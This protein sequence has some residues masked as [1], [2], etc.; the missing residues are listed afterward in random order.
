[1]KY[2]SVGIALPLAIIFQLSYDTGEIPTQWKYAYI[3]PV[4]KKGSRSD[5]I[6]YRPIS[7]TSPVS[8]LMERIVVDKVKFLFMNR[9][10]SRQF[11]F[12]PKKSC[13]LALLDSIYHWQSSLKN[14]KNVDVIY[15]D[16]KSAFDM[17]KHDKLLYKLEKFGF[18]GKLCTW[19]KSF[20]SER[21]SFVRVDSA[22]SQKCF[23][24]PS[25]VLQGTVSG[26]IL[27]LIYINDIIQTIHNYPD[28]QFTLF[29][30]DLKLFGS[31]P[32]SLQAC[33]NDIVNWSNS[34]EIPLAE[35]KINVL[36]LGSNNP[37]V[38]YLLR[39]IPINVVSKVK[40]LGVIIDDKL[41]F[42]AHI[43]AQCI[44]ANA[45]ANKILASFNFNSPFLYMS[46]FK[47]Y[48]QPLLEYCTE[49]FSPRLNSRLLLSLER[50]LRSF[51]KIVFQR[52]GI[53]FD[54]YFDRLNVVG[55]SPL[56]Y[57]RIICDIVQVYKILFGLSHLPI[58]PFQFCRSPRYPLR[59]YSC[60]PM[61]NDN[62]CFFTRSINYWNKVCKEISDL[63]NVDQ[64]R[65]FLK[66][67]DVSIFAP[68][69]NGLS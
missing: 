56:F 5:P 16:F 3:S 24:V 1:M 68:I 25:G 51:S 45:V 57:R 10:I 54:S 21:K 4:F 52:C 13:N 20:L 40:D 33:V 31:N 6:N 66:C 63:K 29:A 19:I 8:R 60:A 67:L 35:N 41:T 49:I 32:I 14:K 22:I 17:I 34:W 64:V 30:D 61:F 26:P 65:E 11:G 59:M 36:H 44:K 38:S 28:V 53:P 2:L 9:F 62:N 37:H 18:D 47:T 7:L 58:H 50:P 43:N 69:P 55:A 48:A 12:L 39:T 15:F 23:N 46:L 42:E 27:F